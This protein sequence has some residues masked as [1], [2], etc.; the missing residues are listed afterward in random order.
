M[1][2][3]VDGLANNRNGIGTNTK[4]STAEV[5]FL[6][7]VDVDNRGS[8]NTAVANPRFCLFCFILFLYGSF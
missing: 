7:R 3:G 8:N 2:F 4:V 6:S 1:T 5:D